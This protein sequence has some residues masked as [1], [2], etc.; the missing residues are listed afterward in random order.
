MI[1]VLFKALLGFLAMAIPTPEEAAAK[2]ARRASQAAP[3]YADGIARV[4]KAPGAAAAEKFEKW[5]QGLQASEGKWRQRVRSVG[6]EE[7]KQRTTEKGVQR[8]ASGVQASEDKMAKFTAEFFPVLERNTAAVRAMPDTTPEQRIQRAV[9]MMRKNAQF[10][11]G[12]SGGPG[13]A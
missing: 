13:G 7:W 6:L 4:T 9:E 1:L 10:R 12:S 2:W 5:R 8:F 11:K 3:D